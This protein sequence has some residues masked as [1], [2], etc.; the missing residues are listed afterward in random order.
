MNKLLPVLILSQLVIGQ[1]IL[2]HFDLDKR[3]HYIGTTTYEFEVD[4]SH[5]DSWTLNIEAIK[6]DISFSGE[7]GNII[8]ITEEVSIWASSGM[9][10][11]SIFDD[12]HAKVIQLKDV[13]IVKITGVGEW[14]ERS[15]FD[16][17]IIVPISTNISVKTAG[18]DIYANRITGEISMTTMGGD[19]EGMHL[20]GKT[21]ARTS[22][23]DIEID[24]S[25]GILALKT[26]GGDII[27]QQIAGEVGANTS[28]GD[29]EVESVQ[30]NVFVQTS[31]G[32]LSFEDIVGS[33]LV[34]STS[35]GSIDAR[36]IQAD[37][38]IQ[39]SGG[40]IDIQDLAGSIK[41][42]TSGGDIE[43][44]EILGNANLITN[45]GDVDV[46]Q[47]HGSI[48][49][50]TSAGNVEII[51]IWNKKIDNHDIHVINEYGSISI[52]LPADFPS[53]ID[54]VVENEI[55][56]NVIDSDFPIKIEKRFDEVKG[57]TVIGEGTYKVKL[58][59]S[60]GTITIEKGTE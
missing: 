9:K 42:E 14:P 26:S 57:E 48:R 41:A 29:I 37:M 28:G 16:Y 46:D 49:A 25:E 35:G 58:R 60:H 12:Y 38:D 44:D 15:A 10:A 21:Y 32:D 34:G 22:G 11:K 54:A 23:G 33:K 5:T 53:Q 8:Q 7:P 20:I 59:T 45:G 1:E 47:L 36:R 19:I 43:V 6:G 50:K 40:D 55:S 3:N 4:D 2:Q 51:K 27:V 39:T 30:G 56:S 17:S 31:G 52:S 24:H 13:R 18:G